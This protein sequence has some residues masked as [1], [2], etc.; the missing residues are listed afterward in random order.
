[1]NN[2]I[3]ILDEYHEEVIVK[4]KMHPILLFLIGGYIFF[5]CLDQVWDL[6]RSYFKPMSIEW[7]TIFFALIIPVVGFAFVFAKK[8]IG[9]IIS[10]LYF[11]FFLIAATFT[12]F[13]EYIENKE[14]ST[15]P[16]DLR[17][18]IFILLSLFI[19]ITLYTKSVRKLLNVKVWMLVI[20]IIISTCLALLL[21]A[22]G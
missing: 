21:V 20:T 6:E 18:S 22:F 10:T 12:T 15:F 14:A 7:E 17:Q 2:E 4:T 13:S 1:M 8:K 9:W 3:N 11:S 16:L 5:F 19:S